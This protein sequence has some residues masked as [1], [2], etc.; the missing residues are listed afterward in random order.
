MSAVAY[1]YLQDVVSTG[2]SVAKAS[3]VPVVWCCCSNLTE[4]HVLIILSLCELSMM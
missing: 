3:A 4:E 2:I 1:T